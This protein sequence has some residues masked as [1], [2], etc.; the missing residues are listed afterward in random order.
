MGE[1]RLYPPSTREKGGDAV[2]DA[3]NLSKGKYNKR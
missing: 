3:L 2:L 1:K